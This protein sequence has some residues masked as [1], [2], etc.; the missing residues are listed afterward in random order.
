M[1][2]IIW[3]RCEHIDASV[4]PLT[5]QTL[6]SVRSL[7]VNPSTSDST[8]SAIFETLIRSLQFSHDERVLKLCSDLAIHRTG[9]SHIIF[10]SIRAHSLL[11]TDSAHIAAEALSILASIAE[12]DRTLVSAMDELDDNFF[13]SLCFR[14]SV[15]VRSR[16]LSSAERFHIRPYLL[17]TVML[18]FTKDPYPYVR[19]FAL[20]GL[21]KLRKIIVC[22]DRDMIQG[23]YGRAAELLGDMED[24]VRSA[25][26]CAVSEWGQLLVGSDQDR[27]KSDWSDVLFVQEIFKDITTF[28]S[29]RAV[30]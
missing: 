6:L 29:A 11:S 13:V 5:P 14:P 3:N 19:R 4:K 8:I 9:F 7:I 23:C 18:G 26:V 20:D 30:W 24:C 1:E 17:L 27:D 21:V 22:D 28:I 12:H 10:N 2:R 16:L 25:A 15:S